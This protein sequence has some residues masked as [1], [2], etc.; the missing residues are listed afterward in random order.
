MPS[1]RVLP[2]YPGPN[3]PQYP[4]APDCI[5][6]LL[7]ISSLRVTCLTAQ[8]ERAA[9]RIHLQKCT[10]T[11]ILARRGNCENKRAAG[12]E[13]STKFPPKGLVKT[14][15]TPNKNYSHAQW[16]PGAWSA[17]KHHAACKNQT[18]IRLFVGCTSL[19]SPKQKSRFCFCS[20]LFRKKI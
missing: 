19:N 10:S 4:V 5:I 9:L 11:K 12:G 13:P 14:T 6:L 20:T 17:R 8:R 3:D 15:G 18:R 16:S 1:W 2:A 7:D